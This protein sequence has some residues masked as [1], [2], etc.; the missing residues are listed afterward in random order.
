MKLEATDI[1]SLQP[2]IAATVRATLEQMQAAESNLGTSRLA[3]TESEAAAALG[4]AKHVL[5]DTRLR[6][7]IAARRVGKRWLYSRDELARFLHGTEA[8]PK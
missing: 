4:V 5:R 2:V 3:F 7:E 8:R 1:A 6:G